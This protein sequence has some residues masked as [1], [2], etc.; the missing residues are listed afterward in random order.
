M[1]RSVR[2]WSTLLCL[3]SVGFLP[4]VHGQSF[5]PTSTATD[6]SA[7]A[8]PARP[9]Q[10]IYV[11][12]F[13][14]DPALQAELE[15]HSG[16]VLPQ[17]PIRQMMADRPRVV[18]MVTGNDR[19]QPVGVTVAKLVADE[20]AK[21]GWPAVF[22][23]QPTQPPADGWRL[24]GQVVLADE[25]SA[26]ARNIIGFGVGNRHVGIDV[27]LADPATAGGE[28]FLILNSSDRGRLT[29]GTAA[30]GAVAGFNPMVIVSKHIASTSGIADITQQQRLA[31]EIATAVAEAIN[32]HTQATRP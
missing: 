8:W 32:Q 30:V 29:P 16:G 27:G 25:G 14:M 15:Q 12:A 2:A 7:G 1:K 28:P 5:G 20:M 13:S 19:S 24:G 22:W 26:A 3:L 11:M 9:P 18:D 31:D 21:A 10:R 6:P 4:V 23:P 17:G